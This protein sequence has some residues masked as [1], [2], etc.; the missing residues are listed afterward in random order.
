MLAGECHPGH[1]ERQELSGP[2]DQPH[3]YKIRSWTRA[4]VPLKLLSFLTVLD[5][6]NA[7]LRETVRHLPS[8]VFICRKAGTL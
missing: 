1:A 5:A 6:E 2:V 3:Q 4:A 7:F 8:K